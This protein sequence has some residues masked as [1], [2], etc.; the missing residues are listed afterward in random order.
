MKKLIVLAL[1]I[2]GSAFIVS[3]FI[4]EDS[5]ADG[6]SPETTY[7]ICYG[8]VLVFEDENYDA[9]K[10][11]YICWQVA[12][13]Q[14]DI[15]V[16]DKHEVPRYETIL[17]P[18]EYPSYQT[19]Y[20]YARLTTVVNGEQIIADLTVLINPIDEVCYVLF[21]YDDDHGYKYQPITSMKSINLSKEAVVDVPENDP[22]R[23]GFR[24]EGWYTDESCKTPFDK[25]TV[26]E[27][28]GNV[29]EYKVYPKW[30]VDSS[31]VHDIVYV[32]LQQ[33][34]GVKYTY[35]SLIVERGK[36]FNLKMDVFED[37]KVDLSGISSMAMDETGQ[38]TVE[39]SSVSESSCVFT[40]KNLTD[41]LTVIFNGYV[42]YSKIVYS[43]GDGISVDGA[44]VEWVKDG[45]PLKVSFNHESPGID[46]NV[47]RNG[48]DITSSSVDGNAV[49][50]GAVTG[51]I[52]IFAEPSDSKAGDGLPI[53][54]FIIIAIVVIM[55]IA[56]LYYIHHR[57]AMQ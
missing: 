46:I 19:N 43:M 47:Y 36:S 26:V 53:Y 16:A 22:K 24:F 57:N 38:K 4:D 15:D 17:R 30:V 49:S 45:A 56:A 41:N 31:E 39:P 29:T 51:T 40:F 3:D 13:N 44:A 8:R 23:N 50:I 11:S 52:Y 18:S 20:I 10:Y 55:L 28:K 32:N 2:L 48:N 12:A 21:M 27:F 6:T 33:I 37:Y 14:S 7:W 42:S 1:L 35:D 25:N 54:L 34:N 5:D 9:S